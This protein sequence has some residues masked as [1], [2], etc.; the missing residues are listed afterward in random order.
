M[1]SEHPFVSALLC[2]APVEVY[3]YG[4]YKLCGRGGGVCFFRAVVAGFEAVL[5]EL[6]ILIKLS[7][8]V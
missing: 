7:G 5:P 1:F 2:P 3:V 8:N 4:I 6:F